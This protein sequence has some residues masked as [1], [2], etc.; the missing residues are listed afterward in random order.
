MQIIEYNLC[1]LFN[2]DTSQVENALGVEASLNYMIALNLAWLRFHPTTPLYRSGVKYGRTKIWEPIPALYIRTYGDCKS[3]SCALI[4]EYL[5][6]GIKCKPV[7]RWAINPNKNGIP[8]YHILV[9]LG[10]RFEDPSKRL[11][12]PVR[13]LKRF[14][15]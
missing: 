12:M 4:A 1:H 5:L 3:L 15:L 7:H 9:Q 14:G 10:D 11:G 2:P 8:D 6:Q 13:E